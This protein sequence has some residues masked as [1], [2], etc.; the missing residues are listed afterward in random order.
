MTKSSESCTLLGI[1]DDGWDGLSPAAQRRLSAADVV[2]GAG[3]TLQLVAAHLA[4][5]ATRHDMDGRLD[6]VAG[7][8]AQA[9]AA[10]R[11]VVVLATGD[12][13]CHGIAS[14]L[15]G[16]LG[17]VKIEILPSLSTL[18]IAFARFQKPWNEFAIASCHSVDAGEWTLG[19][20][21]EHG[22]YALIRTVARNPKVAAF[23]GPHNTP[24]RIARA[25]L[26]AGYGEDA[27]VC[28]ACRLLLPDEQLYADLTP[29]NGR[30][31]RRPNTAS[32]R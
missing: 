31:A 8:V 6:A 2:V 20:T 12:P 5:D 15:A 7:W 17:S 1:L 28:V 19:A 29:A 14:W 23:T 10:G 27:R 25:L 16:K 9:L 13:L 18:Q 22:L 24:A 11:S 26:I 30:S 4:A 32:I 3:R 21:P